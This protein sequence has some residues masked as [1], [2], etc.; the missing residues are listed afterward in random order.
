MVRRPPVY[1]KKEELMKALVC[2][3]T[4]NERQSLPGILDR[5]LAAVP[6]VDVLVIDDNSPDGTGEY[7]AERS[8]ADSR[9]H[10]MHRTEKAGLGKAYIA[11]FTWGIARGYSHL[12]E[13]DADGSHRPEQLVDLLERAQS[14]DEPDV[15]IG[16]RWTRGG[17]VV[18]WPKHRELL[19]RGGNL[20][21]KLWLNLPAKD[22]TAGF[23]VMRSD[24]VARIDFSTIE[25]RGYFFQVDMTRAFHKIGATIVE[26]P[27][28]FI[29]RELGESKMSSTIVVEALLRTTKLGFAERT[30]QLKAQVR[31][32]IAKS[33]A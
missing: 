17:E 1:G 33:K 16:S 26:V 14:D 15:V 27:I 31:R 24:T 13:M 25:S 3:P 9:V 32:C 7:V 10:V 12:C 28:S 23:R 5:V 30:G 21:V 2:I 4:F 20:Y 19:S 6:D 11:G 29:E 22:A 18:N 8:R